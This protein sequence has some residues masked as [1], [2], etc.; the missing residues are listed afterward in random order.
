MQI[1]QLKDTIAAVIEDMKGVDLVS[2]DVRELTDIA[3]YMLV[4]SG[5]S[6]RHVRSIADKVVD[7]LRDQ[8]VRPLGV[9][10]EQAGDWVLLDYGDVVV[11]VMRQPTRDFYELEK[12]WAKDLAGLVRRN[13]ESNGD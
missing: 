2:L 7:E 13:R 9:E 8:G 12:L 11:H 4:A 10:G 3:D 1:E 5:T 6:D